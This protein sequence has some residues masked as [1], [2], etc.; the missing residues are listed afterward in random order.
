MDAEDSHL[1]DERVH[2][3]LEDVREDVLLRVGFRAKFF[4]ARSLEEQRWIAF[5]RIG[6]ELDENF[7]QLGHAGAGSCRHKAHRHEMPLTQRL[8]ER[9]MKLLRRNLALF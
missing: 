1:A 9:C 7:Q 4:G 8:F 6:R 3:D 2:D 5:L